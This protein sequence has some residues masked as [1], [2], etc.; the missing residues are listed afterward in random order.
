MN[1][2]SF[3]GRSHRRAG[4]EAAGVVLHELAVESMRRAPRKVSLTSISTLSTLERSGPQRVTDLAAIE[5]VTQ[6]AMT[7]LLQTLERAGL[8]ERRKDSADKR[9]TLVVPTRT[10][11]SYVRSRRR[12]SAKIIM[13][14]IDELPDGE[15]AAL[16]AAVP[17]LQ[18]LQ[19]PQPSNWPPLADS[20]ATG[21]TPAP[22]QI[23]AADIVIQQ[24]PLVRAPGGV[25]LASEM[26]STADSREAIPVVFLHATG[27]SRGVWRPVARLLADVT[28]GIALDLRGHGN[29][30]KPDSPYE[31][32]VFAQ[33]V[34]AYIE[35]LAAPQVVLCGHSLGGATAVE[36]AAQLPGRV[37]AVTLVEP[38]L[39]PNQGAKQS[40]IVATTLRRTHSW[41]DQAAAEQHL[42]SRSPYRHWDHEVLAEYFATALTHTSDGRCTLSCTPEIE[43]AIYA[44]TGN[45]QAWSQLSQLS[46][47]VWV[48]RATGDQG[49]PSTVSP[50]IT[51]VTPNIV[52]RAVNGSGHFLPM[53]QPGLVAAFIREMLT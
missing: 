32:S 3:P 27:F 53:E 15:A 13:Q 39:S 36:V 37:A 10:G 47:P 41:P 26:T 19:R 28:P 23:T 51:Q 9:V 40:P 21:R 8:V 35:Q 5:G 43:A 1:Q 38:V 44:A 46:C 6:A 4:V 16:V 20:P 2:S 49:M 24:L 29:S 45:S 12:A 17:A 42:A 22:R 31:W 52:D 33:D 50:L 30:D 25:G 48:L 18:H 14:M 11:L 34:A 7:V